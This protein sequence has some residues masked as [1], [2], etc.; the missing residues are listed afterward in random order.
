MSASPVTLIYSRQSAGRFRDWLAARDYPGDL[1]IASNSGEAEA[2]IGDVEI[3]LTAARFPLDLFAH[4]PR[5]RWVQS[6]NAGIEDLVQ[7]AELAPDV[8]LTR[9]VDQFGGPIAEYVFAEVLARVRRIDLLREAQRQ[10]E[11]VHITP[12]TLAGKTLGVAGLGSIGRE[13]AQVGMAFN[14]RTYGLSRTPQ[15]AGLVERHFTPDAW[16][17][18][19]ADVDVLVLTLPH[20]PETAGVVDA[21]IL[22]A[23]KPDALLVNVGRGALVVEDDLAAALQAG[24][25]GGAILDVFQQEPLPADSPLWTLPG[26]T[27]TPHISGPSILE[28]VGDFFLANLH[29]Y[30]QGEPLV[31]LV[32]RAAGY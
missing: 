23:M 27:I 11:W 6:I 15:H 18:F 30:M 32:N 12:G 4:A 8:A 25:P 5:L 22:G 9:I 20:T 14:M 26:V 29:R 1:L 16:P 17:E 2:V 21:R 24:R 19:A 13:V 31:G 10:R 28:D 7:A 3:V